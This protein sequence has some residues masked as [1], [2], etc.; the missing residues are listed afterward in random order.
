MKSSV[1]ATTLKDLGLNDDQIDI[2]LNL[3][4]RGPLTLGEAVL[5]LKKDYDTIQA[6]VELF[7]EKGIVV[8][9]D[10]VPERFEAVPPYEVFLKR[11]ES[12]AKEFETIKSEISGT[13]EEGVQRL[14]KSFAEI[15]SR[16]PE[17]MRVDVSG[18]GKIADDLAKMLEEMLDEQVKA[19]QQRI[20]DTLEERLADL[21]TA[22]DKT[23]QEEL[24]KTQKD[25]SQLIQK[26]GARMA[27][28]GQEIE[29]AKAGLNVLWR[30]TKK[31]EVYRPKNL[32]FVP[33]REGIQAF[34]KD[35]VSRAKMNV[36]IVTP[37]IQD[38]DVDLVR[39][40]PTRVNVR[41]ATYVD[42][43]DSKANQILR[44]LGDGNVTV[45]NYDTKDFW[46]IMVDGSETLLAAIPVD[47]NREVNGIACIAEEY[48][49][50]FR[51]FLADIWL[52]ADRI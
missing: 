37:T 11:F 18:L 2:Y 23:G 41:I 34:F 44:E 45:R 30:E 16:I 15:G 31:G 6:A 50:V 29:E 5:A 25:F 40:L 7:V 36:M 38:V 3:L 1:T 8:R 48:N 39:N 12:F 22:F 28:L 14:G 43:G 51:R 46:G 9:I 21:K 33:G 26:V 47:S 35:M 13:L 10:S 27:E 19:F 42:R 52:A 4:G 32:W 20:V 24:M 17:A 49:Q